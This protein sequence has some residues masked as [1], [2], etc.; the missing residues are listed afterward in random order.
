MAKVSFKENQPIQ[1]LS[2]TV[3][4][5]TFRTMNIRR[6]SLAMTENTVSIR[7]KI[8]PCLTSKKRNNDTRNLQLPHR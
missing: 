7:M 3:G 5:I 4:N 2:G 6:Q 8:S 1:S